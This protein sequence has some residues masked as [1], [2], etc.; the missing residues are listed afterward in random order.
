MLDNYTSIQ[1]WLSDSDISPILE[2]ILRTYHE[3]KCIIA[4]NQFNCN[5]P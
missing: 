1:M 2:H 5:L 3:E 4:I